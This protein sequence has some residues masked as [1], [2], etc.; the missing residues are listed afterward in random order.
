MK[1]VTENIFQVQLSIT[2]DGLTCT[3]SVKPISLPGVLRAWRLRRLERVTEK[4]TIKV[5]K[6]PPYI[7]RQDTP[8]SPLECSCPGFQGWNHCKHTKCMGKLL[9]LEMSTGQE[10]SVGTREQSEGVSHVGRSVAES[11]A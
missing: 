9:C 6:Q 10:E 3:Y 7:V 11:V 4:A 2:K 8:E 5:R 1:Q